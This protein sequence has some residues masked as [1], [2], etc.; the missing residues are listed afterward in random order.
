MMMMM[1]CKRKTPACRSADFDTLPAHTSL[2]A[3]P[4]RALPKNERIKEEQQQQQHKTNVET[5]M[6]ENTYRY[7]KCDGITF[8]RL[9]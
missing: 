2:L 7:N 6:Y 5:Y 9:R 3:H 1:M 8:V 4:V